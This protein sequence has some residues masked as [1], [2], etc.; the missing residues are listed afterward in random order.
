MKCFDDDFA[1]YGG[2]N[3]RNGAAEFLHGG[4]F[5]ILHTGDNV[6]IRTCRAARAPQMVTTAVRRVETAWCEASE[7]AHFARLEGTPGTGVRRGSPTQD[8]NR[9]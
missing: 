7:L 8:V 3:S 6:G 4:T 5:P 9:V 1:G 2:A